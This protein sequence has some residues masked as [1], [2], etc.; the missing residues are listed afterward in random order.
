M[1]DQI[2]TRGLK[3][4]IDSLG[5]YRL[6]AKLGHGGMGTVHLGVVSG[7]GNFRKLVV[8][9]E[10]RADLC[11]N[12]QFIE[13][14]LAEAKLAA[15]LNHPNVV[16]TLEADREG[17]RYFLAMEFLD[18]HPLSEL[19][20]HRDASRELPLGVRLRILTEVLS[21]LHYA[22]ELKGYDGKGVHVVHRDVSPQNVFVTYDGQVK[23]LDF[24]IAKAEGDES[25]TRPGIFKGKLAYASPEQV[26]G[27]PSD[28]R[29]D[30]FA[31]GVMLWEAITMRRFSPGVATR[32]AVEARISGGEP[33]VA[34]VAPHTH[35]ALAAICD[36]AL[37]VDP[38]LRY[39]T[40]E[41][42]R[43]A[44]LSFIRTSAEPADAPLTGKILCSL[45]AAE[46]AEMHQLISANLNVDDNPESMV[47][48]LSLNPGPVSD[49]APTTVGDLSQLIETSAAGVSRDAEPD[50]EAHPR[51]RP[52]RRTVAFAVVGAA[53]IAAIGGFLFGS[54]RGTSKPDAVSE[55]AAR[56]TLPA[57]TQTA[58]PAETSDAPPASAAAVR[59]QG[60][61][62]PA[63]SGFRDEAPV[64]TGA[65]APRGFVHRRDPEP[66]RRASEDKRPAASATAAEEMG[67]DLR[68]LRRSGSP[69]I[70]QDNPYRRTT[71]PAALDQ[72]NPY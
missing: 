21:G 32:A 22:H 54:A 26:R 65:L 24:G 5:R 63:P 50:F 27:L 45:F 66:L 18:G 62:A 29:G 72:D 52:D 43:E 1:V 3:V 17:E 47:R 23:L 53:L 12:T 7:L 20:R 30:V 6:V 60:S 31:A 41:E 4:P 38:A 51:F 25:L 48:V 64:G 67:D 35:P 8:V 36:R 34:Q 46:R 9:K 58:V 19:L 57:V 71:P 15:R 56:G 37:A 55:M 59:A 68:K 69:S 33:R 10:L 11:R 28:R 40:A 49:D 61:D 70:D 42:L 13:M 44:L 39:Q 16:Q 2:T 14:F